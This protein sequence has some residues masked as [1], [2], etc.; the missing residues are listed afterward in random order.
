MMITDREL[1]IYW[2]NP[3]EWDDCLMTGIH[4]QP[5]KIHIRSYTPA[6]IPP[7]LAPALD[8]V[9]ATWVGKDATWRA[10]QVIATIGLTTGE[11]DADGRAVMV[12]CVNLVVYAQDSDG[13]SM[14]FTPSTDP[15]CVITDPVAL[16]FFRYFTGGNS[17]IINS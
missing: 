16:E 10:R 7:A 3:G 2:P 4:R 17:E 12:G 1:Q 5:G 13:G 6:D 8:G 11:Q 15:A 14:V 9:V